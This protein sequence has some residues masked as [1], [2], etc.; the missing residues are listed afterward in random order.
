MEQPKYIYG[1]DFG[2]TNS[3]LSILE[4]ETKQIVKTISI[5]SLLYFVERRMRDAPFL[6]HIGEHAMNQY[7][8]S[9]MKGRFMKSIKRVLPRPGFQETTVYFKKMTA[10][11]LVSLVIRS[12]K[13]QADE[14]LGQEVK[15]AV[16]GRPVFFDEEPK[17]DALA[18]RRLLKA[19][20]LAGLENCTF[21]YEPIGAAYA[22]L[23]NSEG[24][25]TVLVGDFGGGTSDF[26]VVRFT[27]DRKIEKVIGR[28]G[29]YVGGDNFDAQIM[30]E[31]VTPQLGRGT[32]YESFGKQLEV[33]NTFFHNICSWEKLNF[34]NSQKIRNAIKKYH[35]YTKKDPKMAKLLALIDQNL[36]YSL[37][38]KVEQAK[39]ELSSNDLAEI[40]FEKDIVQVQSD[41]SY[42]DFEAITKRFIFDIRK[43]L[44]DLLQQ[45]SLATKDIDTVFLTGGSSAAK[46]IRKIFEDLF[47]SEKL[48]AG[49]NFNSV[50]NGLAMSYGE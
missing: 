31:K 22:Y 46:P 44:L 47:D 39:I 23:G 17:K 26:T 15:T 24:A 34:F 37:Y 9:K 18:Q 33:P 13:E 43:T 45:H 6:Y 42:T 7:I 21:Q 10:S 4:V 35:F 30:W 12:L 11:D 49:D 48:K 29:I 20:N 28:S 50:S 27:N 3:A 38:R 40:L 32:T 2:T 8:E 41:L 16:L 36:G 14:W 25:K 1:I 19:A 5:P